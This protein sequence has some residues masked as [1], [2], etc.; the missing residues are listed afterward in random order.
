MDNNRDSSCVCFLVFEIIFCSGDS[1]H[2]RVLMGPGDPGGW[3]QCRTHV[4]RVR[5]FVAGWRLLVAPLPPRP[6]RPQA[7]NGSGELG[8]PRPP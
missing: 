6:L 7:A 8:A 4:S 5:A 3:G 2:C 1:P